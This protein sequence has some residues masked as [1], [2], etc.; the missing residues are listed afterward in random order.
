MML[1]ILCRGNDVWHK[2]CAVQGIFSDRLNNGCKKLVLISV[3]FRKFFLEPG[4]NSAI[5]T[6]SYM[7]RGGGG[8]GEHLFIMLCYWGPTF[9]IRNSF[10]RNLHCTKVKKALE[11]FFSF[12]YYN[13][14]DMVTNSSSTTNLCMIQTFTVK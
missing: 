10:I 7:F 5:L 11:T 3:A 13:F 9:Y 4:G 12:S 8:G 2:Y 1:C 14:E 6:F